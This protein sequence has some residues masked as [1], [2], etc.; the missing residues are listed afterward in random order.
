MQ[1][2]QKKRNAK[3]PIPDGKL[4]EGDSILLKDHITCVGDPRYN[5]D[6]QIIYFP[7]KTQANVVDSKGKEKM[8]HI[9]DIK[10]VLPADRVISKLPDYKSFGRQL[11][12]RTDPRNIPNIR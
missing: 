9:S 4:S 8:V 6:Y 7:T 11:K 12:L 3:A 1:A 10:Y 5:G 2:T